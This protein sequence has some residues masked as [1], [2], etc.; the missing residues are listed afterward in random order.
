M[1]IKGWLIEYFLASTLQRGSLYAGAPA[2]SFF[3]LK[4]APLER[5]SLHSHA[6]ATV[7]ELA[8]KRSIHIRIYRPRQ[9]GRR[10]RI[11]YKY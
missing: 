9:I 10:N 5:Y 2:P 4:N 8:P 3:D 1:E 11:F 7:K 6:G